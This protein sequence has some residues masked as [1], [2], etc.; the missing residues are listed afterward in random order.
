VVEELAQC[1]FKPAI[2][3]RSKE[4]MKD[5]STIMKEYNKTAHE[6]LFL[7]AERRRERKVRVLGRVWKA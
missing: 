1:S 3:S 6:L 4:L 2:N 7:D 5:R